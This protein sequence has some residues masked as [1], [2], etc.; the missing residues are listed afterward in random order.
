MSRVK[1]IDIQQMTQLRAITQRVCQFLQNSLEGYL[2]PLSSLLAPD[3]TLGEYMEGPARAT[4]TSYAE[5][6]EKALNLLTERY[7][8]ICRDTF[9]Y[10]PK[11]PTPVPAIKF[12][13]KLYPWEY[14]HALDGDSA[15]TIAVYSPTQ[16]VLAYDLPYTLSNLHKASTSQE[17]PSPAETKQLIINT[18]TLW[19]GME[20]Q[21]AVKQILEDLRFPVAV[22]SSSVT[23]ELPFLVVSSVV[24]SFRPKDDLI[25]M[26][27][28]LSGKPVFEE[29]VDL[30]EINR[31]KDSFVDKLKELAAGEGAK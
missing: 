21:P 28:Q 20:R 4:R 30:D 7:A 16:W 8:A 31:V 12:K 13:L 29:L 10:P 3:K 27:T 23:G 6:A 5:K 15:R 22:K 25:Q 1:E 11:L 26:V 19:I 17:K 9:S 18:V 2:L 14:L 24:E